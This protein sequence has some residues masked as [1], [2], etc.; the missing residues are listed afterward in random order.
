[1]AGIRIISDLYFKG[2]TL[3]QVKNAHPNLIPALKDAKAKASKINEGKDNE[4]NTVKSTY[5]V[6]YHDESPAKACVE[7][8][9]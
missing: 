9:I 4:E 1:M 7:L 8:E 5:H 3:Q 2:M 6:C